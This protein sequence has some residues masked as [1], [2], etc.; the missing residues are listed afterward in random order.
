MKLYI[1]IA[2]ALLFSCGGAH[3]DHDHD[4]D[5]A[6]EA[7]HTEDSHADHDHA[8]NATPT[9]ESASDEIVLSEAQLK[10]FNIESEQVAP[11]LFSSA[12]RTGG[13]ILPS[14]GDQSVVAA[15]AEG[16]VTF[17]A[18][19]M[20][21]GRAVSKGQVL[22]TIS[23]RN[24]EGGEA[25]AR[26]KASYDAAKKQY[27]RAVGLATDKI[28]SKKELEQ[29]ELNYKTAKIAYE[30]Q[31]PSAS[32]SG[33]NI[34]AP[35][36]GYLTSIDVTNGAYVALGTPL[37]TVAQNKR[38]TIRADVP[39]KYFNQLATISSA[40]F[41][42][43]HSDKLYSTKDLNGRKT[44][45][46]QS[47]ADGS[48]YLNVD[49]ELDNRG[50]LLAGSLLEIYL[51][52]ASRA[53]VISVPISSLLEQEGHH[54]VMV[55]LDQECFEKREV[56]LGATNGERTEILAGLKAGES[57]VTRGAFQVKMASASSAIP[58]GHNH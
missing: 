54:Y 25:Y 13:R 3:T 20:S 39:S 1:L 15:T 41:S 45:S 46:S 32:G 28:V 12:I 24:I 9:A 29:A 43:S 38:L 50:D 10:T 37:A 26:V 49:F 14:S 55:R 17:A 31:T 2:A 56:N 42:P 8:E 57:V 30:A 44:A 40:N 7:A 6:T 33:V 47:L 22:F 53:D 4:H 21:L 27:D 16:I 5:H 34:S 23:S 11:A 51:I 48:S 35:M 58:D 36:S 18:P 19:S 52:G